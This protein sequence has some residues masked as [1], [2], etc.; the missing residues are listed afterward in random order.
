MIGQE[1]F[2]FTHVPDEEL[3]NPARV[4]WQGK[5]AE[6]AA[7]KA[8]MARRKEVKRLEQERIVKERAARLHAIKNVIP[9][10]E[11]LATEICG[12]ISDGEL[13]LSICK[14]ENTPTVRRVNEWL[15]DHSDFAQLYEN[16]IRDRLIIFE[17]QTIEISDSMQNDFKTIVK[18]G[19]ERRVVDP[20]V[21]ARAK[22]RVDSRHKYLKA[23]KPERWGEQ[24][25]L[26]V[27]NTSDPVA[28]MPLDELEKK[29]AE[30]EHKDRVVNEDRRSQAA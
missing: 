28:D 19:K 26:N 27:N 11:A 5:D 29:I 15:K 10:S 9:Y 25:T 7:W 16:A 6:N 20:E 12:R 21:I 8:E 2:D 22:L 23:Y 4:F 30:L 17:E 14:E 13:L 3:Y 24:S 1:Q 18:N